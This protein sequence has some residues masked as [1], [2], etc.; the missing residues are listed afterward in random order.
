MMR[1]RMT[2]EAIAG[3]YPDQQMRCPV[4]LCVG[5]E[6]IAT[7]V[8][9]VL[10]SRDWAVSGHRS[11]G[12]YLARG[13]DLPAMLAELYGRAT[14]CCEGKGGSMHLIDLEAGF[15]G[16]VPI[17]GSTVP[18][19]VGAAFGCSM[20][21]EDRVVVVYLGD[22]AMEEGVAHESLNFARLK[23]LGVVF[24]CENNLYSVYT[25]LR[26]R[27]PPERSLCDLVR[28]HGIEAHEGDGNDVLEV[29]RLAAD[30]VEAARAGRGPVF[31]E[32]STYR[33]RE[34]CGPHY[35][36]ELGYREEGELAGWQ[37]R[38]PIQRFEALVLEQGLMDDE[39]IGAMRNEVAEEI[40][41]AFDFARRSPF[42]EK[43]RL[44]ADVLAD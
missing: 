26:E 2:E 21:S 23:R 40:G 22:G 9:D 42:P 29:R 12:H 43:E 31:L 41:Q 13:G 24:V 25:H 11:H 5:Q 38:C 39:S 28:G 16:A 44:F 18:I 8:S 19:G 4:H 27:Q 1:T 30:A 15:L 6:A 35:D 10:E 37:Q 7:G 20:R 32:L 33:W 36:D 14:G 34:H 17:V 3:E